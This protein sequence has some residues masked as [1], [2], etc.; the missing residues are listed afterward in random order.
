MHS[1]A[2]VYLLDRCP[3][4][5]CI[6]MDF[7]PMASLFLPAA[8]DVY[9]KCIVRSLIVVDSLPVDVCVTAAHGAFCRLCSRRR[10]DLATGDG[11]ACFVC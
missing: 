10:A 7:T 1:S 9:S 3:P 2:E 11:R 6:E 8:T 5:Y 4:S